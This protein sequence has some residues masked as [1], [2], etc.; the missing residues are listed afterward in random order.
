MSL[1]LTGRVRILPPEEKRRPVEAP[2]PASGIPARG[3]P[4]N[5]SLWA[6][7]KYVVDYLIAHGVT[8]TPEQMPPNVVWPTR[9]LSPAEFTEEARK[10]GPSI[11]D[12]YNAARLHAPEWGVRVMAAERLKEAA[13]GKANQPISHSVETMTPAEMDARIAELQA[14][15]AAREPRMIEG[16]VVHDVEPDA[17]SGAPDAQEAAPEP[18]VF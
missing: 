6:A 14:K 5:G 12:T 3:L 2:R 18:P 15:Q 9:K 11:I 1:K 13:Y 8:I 4:A 10:Y 7:Q 16:T 17:P